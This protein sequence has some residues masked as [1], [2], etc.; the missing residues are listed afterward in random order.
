MDT[1]HGQLGGHRGQRNEERRG[2]APQPGQI[3]IEKSQ[4]KKQRHLTRSNVT[5][6]SEA[7]HPNDPNKGGRVSETPPPPSPRA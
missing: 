3:S 7:P 5:A 1:E 2:W 6:S 4:V